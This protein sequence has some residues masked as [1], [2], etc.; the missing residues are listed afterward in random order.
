MMN[1]K[2]YWDFDEFEDCVARGLLL[3]YESKSS[4]KMKSF[5]RKFRC[6]FNYSM[7]VL[8]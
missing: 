3:Q 6:D 5:E 7:R 2:S 4:N 1:E 8:K